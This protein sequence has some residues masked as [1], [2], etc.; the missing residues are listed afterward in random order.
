MP[1]SVRERA[2]PAPDPGD[3]LRAT[4]APSTG[5]LA[6][7]K[8]RGADICI[9]TSPVSFEYYTYAS[10]NPGTVAAMDSS[11]SS[12]RR[13]PGTSTSSICM[14]GRVRRLLQDVDHLNHVGAPRF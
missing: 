9:V 4:Q 14:P 6:F 12:R 8:E 7:L 1:A 11:A 13:A 10:R 3:R 5:A 2:V